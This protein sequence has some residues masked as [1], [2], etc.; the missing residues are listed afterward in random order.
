M[1]GHDVDALIKLCDPAIEVR[2]SFAA[3]GGGVYRG[4]AGVRVWQQDLEESWG[5]DFC[6]VLEAFFDFGERTMALGELRGR[7]T[8]S[9]V[10]VAMPGISVAAWRGALCVSHMG[11]L[12]KEDALAELNVAEDALQPIAP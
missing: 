6:V 11:Y 4:H 8:Q 2:S 3:V 5:G 12:N 7:G 1:N 9:G 10:E